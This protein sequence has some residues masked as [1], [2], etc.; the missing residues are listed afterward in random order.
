MLRLRGSFCDGTGDPV[1]MAHDALQAYRADVAAGKD[2]LLVCDTTEMC[3]ALNRRI[4]DESVDADAPAVTGARG[5]RIGKGDVIVSRRNDPTLEVYSPRDVHQRAEDPVRNGQRWHVFAVDPDHNRIAARRLED[6]ARTVFSGDYL[7][8]HIIHGY[9]VTVHSAQGVTADVT[10]AVLGEGASRNLL[11]V[12]MTRGRESNTAYLYERLAGE[13]DHE[14]AQPTPGVHVARRGSGREAASSCAPSSP[15]TTNRP[16][17]PTT[18]PPKTPTVSS[19]PTASKGSSTAVP[20]PWPS[21]ET[22]TRP[23]ADKPATGSSTG[24]SAAISSSAAAATRA[25]STA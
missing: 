4:H 23:G 20:T 22:T 9:A 7:R 10:H 2:A 13:G 17:P 14:H 18:S 19:C 12:A 5:H 8:E 3:D 25:S 11:Y 15:T 24:N 6:G 1:A 16:T 21:G